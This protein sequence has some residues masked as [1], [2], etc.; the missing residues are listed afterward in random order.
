MVVINIAYWLY[1]DGDYDLR[2]PDD[3]GCKAKD[4]SIGDDYYN[5]VGTISFHSV[6]HGSA[7]SNAKTWLKKFLCEGIQVNYANYGLLTV[8][9]NMVDD[10]LEFIN[11][12]FT[13]DVII[14]SRGGNHEGTHIVV[15]INYI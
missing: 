9:C 12:T 8:F 5:Y 2:N 3:F 4:I 6:D 13:D 1:T 15:S 14:K 10:L 11:N 7:K